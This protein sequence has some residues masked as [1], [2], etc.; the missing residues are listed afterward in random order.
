M[1]KLLSGVV[2]FGLMSDT[3]LCAAEN[4]ELWEV[5]SKM[6]MPGLP[7]AMWASKDKNCIEAGNAKDPDKVI[8]KY[9]KDQDCSMGNVIISGKNS[10][11]TMSCGGT[12]PAAGSGEMT[13]GDGTFRGKSIMQSMGGSFTLVY[14]GKRIGTCQEK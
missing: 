13:L 12:S 14:E 5:T 7:F 9:L 11:W 4:G 1:R 3:N 10:S 6:L 8:P 2:I